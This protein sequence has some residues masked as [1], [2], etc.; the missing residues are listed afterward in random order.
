[1]VRLR[2]PNVFL[3]SSL[4]KN[5]IDIRNYDVNSNTPIRRKIHSVFGSVQ[6]SYQNQAVP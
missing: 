6:L 2:V 3:E 5:T 4:D 1:M